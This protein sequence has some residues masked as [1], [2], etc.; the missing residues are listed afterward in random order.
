MTAGNFQSAVNV[1]L[2]FGVP[3]ELKTNEPNRTESLALD[4]VGGTIGYFFTKDNATNVA[5]VGG[6]IGQGTSSFTGS[7]STTVLT[8]TAI[9][10]GSIQI[11]QTLTGPTSCTVTAYGTGSGGLGTYTVSVSQTFGSGAIT[12]AGGPLTVMAGILV[13][14]KAYALFGSAG[15]PID[16]SLVL[17]AYTQGEFC[18]MGTV[19]AALATAGKIGDVIVYDVVT[20]ALSAVAPGAAYG[21]RL[22]AV[23]NCVLYRYPTTAAGLVAV[24]L[25]N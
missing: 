9:S 23:P 12:G 1:S 24:R 8:V 21:N 16:P 14:P 17:P 3:G 2:A 7:I 13:N 4:S 19:V 18:T 22:T 25:T 6:V 11:G 15:S 20:G 10:A 5:S